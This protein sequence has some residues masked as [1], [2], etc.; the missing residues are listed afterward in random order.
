MRQAA[1]LTSAGFGE[2][3]GELLMMP[4]KVDPIVA[5]QLFHVIGRG[6][7]QVERRRVAAGLWMLFCP[8]PSHLQAGLQMVSGARDMVMWD[9]LL[10]MLEQVAPDHTS[11]VEL[12]RV[13]SDLFEG[14]KSG[15]SGIEIAQSPMAP[16]LQGWVEN[17]TAS[18]LDQL[19]AITEGTFRAE[20]GPTITPIESG[21]ATGPSYAEL[22]LRRA[23]EGA[24]RNADL[25]P[26]TDDLEPQR[27]PR[28]ERHLN[29][30]DDMQNLET[31][32][33]GLASA[34]QRLADAL[35]DRDPEAIAGAK[36]M[37]AVAQAEAVAEEQL[38]LLG[39]GGR[40]EEGVAL[41][42]AEKQWMDS[43]LQ[44]QGNWMQ[45]KTLSSKGSGFLL[46][47]IHI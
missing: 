42:P 16:R 35:L 40:E 22:Q 23:R 11:P 14:S 43:I 13:A 44:Q 9:E 15:K 28:P 25:V 12:Q 37:L 39:T 10:A 38:E 19:V 6:R 46:S 21:V 33:T 47:L 34:K 4:S 3:L 2:F 18:A 31:R 26:G 7:A 45:E 17:W 8:E 27:S 24:T 20:N 5:G 41:S 36:R 30:E 1:P 29:T 32:N